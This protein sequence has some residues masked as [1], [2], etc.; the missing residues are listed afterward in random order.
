MPV[1]K[2]KISIITPTLNQADFIEDTIRSVIKQNYDNFEHIIM[3][4]GSS[5]HT[6]EILNKYPHLKWKSEKDSGQSNAIN[7]GFK[8]ADGDIIAWINSDDFYADNIFQDV[9]TY[10]VKNPN[11]KFLYGN[12]TYIDKN[13]KTLYSITGAN[14][15]YHNL[16]LYPDIVRQPSSFWRREV[17]E[18]I[19]YLNETL[20]VVM[21]YEYFLRISEKYESYYFDRNLSFFRCYHENKTN[22]LL[23]KQAFELYLVLKHYKTKMDFKTYKFLFGRYLDSLSRKNPVRIL[24]QT[25]RKG[26]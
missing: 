5:D 15:N 11:C 3:D 8:L 7:K 12:I 25:V 16:L 13:R 22:S 14:I 2:L 18:N 6:L 23:R 24:F 20:H 17:L 26:V 1:N 4:G 19:G 10:F 9:V 21:D